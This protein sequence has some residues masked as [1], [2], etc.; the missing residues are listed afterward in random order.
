ML[1]TR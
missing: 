1:P